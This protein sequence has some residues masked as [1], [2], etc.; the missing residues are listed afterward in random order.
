MVGIELPSNTDVVTSL[1]SVDWPQKPRAFIGASSSLAT[2]ALRGE[3]CIG[4]GI[5][6]PDCQGEKLV[7]PRPWHSDLLPPPDRS[8]SDG[9]PGSGFPAMSVV[10]TPLEGHV[11]AEG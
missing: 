5:D 11:E 8:R 2:V 4:R 3:D 6:T 7:V 1:T 9:S 10:S